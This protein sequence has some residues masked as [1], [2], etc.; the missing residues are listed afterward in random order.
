MLE[1]ASMSQE[2]VLTFAQPVQTSP[3]VQ[4]FTELPTNAEGKFRIEV[5]E[6]TVS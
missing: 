1:Q 4:W 2:T 5:N 3:L 6:I